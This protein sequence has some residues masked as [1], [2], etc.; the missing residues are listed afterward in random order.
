MKTLIQTAYGEPARVLELRE[1]PDQLP[2]TGEALI[3]VEA[4]VV[5]MADVHT[6]SGRA[7]FRKSLPR[8]PGYEGVGRVLALGAGG[9]HVVVVERVLCP[10]GSGTHREP[11]SIKARTLAPA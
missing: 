3:G 2:D 7:G 5:Q 1:E 11:Y 10:V 6:V 4:A 8:T 9:S